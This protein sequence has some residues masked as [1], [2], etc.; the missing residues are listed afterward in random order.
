MIIWL[1]IFKPRTILLHLDLC[2]IHNDAEQECV[3]ILYLIVNEALWWKQIRET[4]SIRCQLV[5]K[6]HEYNP[7]DR[8]ESRLCSL[9][10]PSVSLEETKRIAIAYYIL[11]CITFL[12]HALKNEVQK[13]YV[14]KGCLRNL[15]KLTSPSNGVFTS[16]EL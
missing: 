10:Q 3:H 2:L 5:W 6:G 4:L 7:F 13:H 12:L 15:I 1:C 14:K 8:W 9:F 16:C 11:V